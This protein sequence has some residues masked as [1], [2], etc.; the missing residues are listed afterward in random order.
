MRLL[1]VDRSSARHR[2]RYCFI[3]IF[4]L[5]AFTVARWNAAGI[6]PPKIKIG[7]L[8]LHDLARLPEWLATREIEPVRARRH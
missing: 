4:A 7:K 3:P 1:K 8:I 2:R 6:G 5:S